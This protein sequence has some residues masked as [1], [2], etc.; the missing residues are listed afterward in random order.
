MQC[1]VYIQLLQI[2]QCLGGK[3]LVW[4]RYFRSYTKK[5]NA[6]TNTIGNTII[7]ANAIEGFILELYALRALRVSESSYSIMVIVYI[8]VTGKS[9][10]TSQNKRSIQVMFNTHRVF[11]E[12]HTRGRRFNRANSLSDK[13]SFHSK[14]ASSRNCSLLNRNLCTRRPCTT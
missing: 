9:T 3:R 14:F 4:I 1:F 7:R 8:I 11:P 5:I 13:E 6:N 2:R 10:H 12:S